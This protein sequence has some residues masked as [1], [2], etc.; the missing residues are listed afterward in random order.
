MRDSTKTRP[1]LIEITIDEQPF[2]VEEKE[3]T[4]RELLALVNKNADSYYLVEIK[5]KKERKK[6]TDPDE[7]VKLH[8]GSKFVAV[9]RGETPVS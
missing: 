7:P 6:Y 5:G 3:M 9:F 1:K 2:E 4:V 8:K